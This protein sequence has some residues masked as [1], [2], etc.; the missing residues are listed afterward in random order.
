MKF[1]KKKI[2]IVLLA[3]ATVALCIFGGYSLYRKNQE[4]KAKALY[5]EVRLRLKSDDEEEKK[6]AIAKL[7]EI[8][9]K[10]PK[11]KSGNQALYDV[12]CTYYDAKEYR[13]AIEAFQ[14]SNY[15]EPSRQKRLG[16]CFY[17]LKEQEEALLHY[18]KVIDLPDTLGLRKDCLENMVNIAK[19]LKDETKELEYLELFCKDYSDGSVNSDFEHNYEIRKEAL[20]AKRKS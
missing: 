18:Q 16:D 1:N 9:Q 10:Y 14:E 17:K 7:K 3:L 2:G 15:A 11:T 20:K 6:E 12:G 5:N 4:K 8:H 13:A 19:A